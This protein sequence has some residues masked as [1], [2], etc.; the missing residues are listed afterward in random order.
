LVLGIREAWR[1]IDGI[2]TSFDRRRDWAMGKNTNGWS[3]K[4]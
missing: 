2:E 4:M 3:R 1:D